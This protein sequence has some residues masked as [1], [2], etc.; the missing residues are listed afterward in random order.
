MHVFYPFL[1][2][3]GQKKCKILLVIDPIF[4]ILGEM[5]KFPKEFS[6]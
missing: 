5:K 4:G 6:V 1:H 2:F 3:L